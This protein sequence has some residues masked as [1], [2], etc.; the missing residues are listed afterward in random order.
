MLSE[1]P[2]LPVRNVQSR[3]S[4]APGC[5]RRWGKNA[6]TEF[7]ATEAISETGAGVAAVANGP[8]IDVT[9]VA[10]DADAATEEEE[11][12]EEE[13]EEVDDDEEDTDEDPASAARSCDHIVVAAGG[14]G[15]PSGVAVV[16]PNDADVRSRGARRVAR[17]ASASCDRGGA[18][19]VGAIRSTAVARPV[20]CASPS[21][22]TVVASDPDAFRMT[23]FSGGRTRPV[24]AE[25][26][27]DTPVKAAE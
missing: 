15:D 2:E 4:V 7:Q 22:L 25:E 8:A 12:D 18:A 10:G 13:E 3:R 20:A 26:V 9:E 17:V 1:T 11:E 14:A 23:A 27:T 21:G 6:A 19:V 5:G 24:S 16:A